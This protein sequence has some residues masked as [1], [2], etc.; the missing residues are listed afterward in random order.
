MHL[1]IQ[2]YI[3]ILSMQPRRYDWYDD[4][5]CLLVSRRTIRQLAVA[6]TAWTD[7]RS[8]IVRMAKIGCMKKTS[9]M[10][11]CV[12]DEKCHYGNRSDACFRKCEVCTIYY[13]EA[14]ILR[15][16][17]TGSICTILNLDQDIFAFVADRL[18]KKRQL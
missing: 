17:F 7:R 13:I 8:R 11:A 1:C 3:T 10:L 15:S 5:E 6:A 18:Q 9:R 12:L 2:C 4:M 16:I 14:R